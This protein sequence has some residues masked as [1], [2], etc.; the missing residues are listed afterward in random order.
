MKSLFF[1]LP[2]YICSASFLNC[3]NK[4]NNLGLIVEFGLTGD[5]LPEN[6][7]YWPFIS[8][9]IYSIPKKEFSERWA[10]YLN[11]VPLAGIVI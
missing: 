8:G 6:N 5:R 11:L 10:L 7:I 1:L 4:N 2:F 3:Q 9:G